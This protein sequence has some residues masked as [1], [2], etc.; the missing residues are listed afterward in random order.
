MKKQR[1]KKER[2]TTPTGTQ[3]LSTSSPAKSVYLLS[4]SAQPRTPFLF[5]AFV[6]L[7]SSSSL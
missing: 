4:F 5:F 1:R 7:P 2:K 6:L 3:E